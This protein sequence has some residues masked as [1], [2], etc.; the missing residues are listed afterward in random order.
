MEISCVTESKQVAP[1]LAPP[2]A[3]PRRNTGLT[4]AEGER[5]W[6]KIKTHRRQGAVSEHRT[7]SCGTRPWSVPSIP[8]HTLYSY[9]VTMVGLAG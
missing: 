6:L 3:G 7:E 4:R 5:E 9:N 1:A 2:S 8:W